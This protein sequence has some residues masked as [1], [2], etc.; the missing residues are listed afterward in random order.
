MAE[1][2][3]V[4]RECGNCGSTK[5]M[6]IN[7]GRWRCRGCGTF[8]DVERFGGDYGDGNVLRGTGGRI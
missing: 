5:E 2:V 3:T 4:E 8:N 7:S 1:P 6:E